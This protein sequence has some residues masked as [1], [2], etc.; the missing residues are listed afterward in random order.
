MPVSALTALQAKSL[1]AAKGINVTQT[2]NIADPE[3]L[4]K[5][6]EEKC[7]NLQA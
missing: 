4:E 7:Q 5:Q 2:V 3:P 6:S 1:W